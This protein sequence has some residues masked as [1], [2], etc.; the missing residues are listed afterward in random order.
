[1]CMC[2]C[3]C[4]SADARA[5][6]GVDA[7]VGASKG[8]S[9]DCVCAWAWDMWARL[10]R[11]QWDGD[12]REPREAGASG[13]TATRDEGRQIEEG[14]EGRLELRA[15]RQGPQSPAAAALEVLLR[16]CSR[17]LC[18]DTRASVSVRNSSR[19]LRHEER[20]RHADSHA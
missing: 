8:A 15:G 6:L 10:A 5:G 13:A 20:K 18:T 2:M 12:V 7:S 17:T 3:M 9:A 1:M 16:R 4:M 19:A 14:M 11:Q